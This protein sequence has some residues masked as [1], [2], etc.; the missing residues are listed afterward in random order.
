MQEIQPDF[1]SI[2]TPEYW[3]EIPPKHSFKRSTAIGKILELRKKEP[4]YKHGKLPSRSAEHAIGEAL[5]R[6]AFD[7]H[8]DSSELLQIEDGVLLG[9]KD[10]DTYAIPGNIL[11][12]DTEC[13]IFRQGIERSPFYGEIRNEFEIK[14]SALQIIKGRF[15]HIS[16]YTIDP[17]AEFGKEGPIRTAASFLLNPFTEVEPYEKELPPHLKYKPYER[18]T[19]NPEAGTYQRSVDLVAFFDAKEDGTIGSR[20]TSGSFIYESGGAHSWLGSAATHRQGKVGKTKNLSIDEGALY[21]QRTRSAYL[22]ARGAFELAPAK[23]N[24]KSKKVQTSPVL[25][26]N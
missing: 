22:C 23:T 2:Y 18:E 1:K 20:T 3:S 5:A 9:T 13:V 8:N 16:S 12:L 25:N 10:D 17:L 11:L 14:A 4:R 26:T 6:T 19:I 21:L 24:K 7:I 15:R